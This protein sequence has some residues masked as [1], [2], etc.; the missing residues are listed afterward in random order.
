MLSAM[1]DWVKRSRRK[2]G[3]QPMT[4]FL[5]DKSNSGFPTQ[6]PHYTDEESIGHAASCVVQVEVGNSGGNCTAIA[7]GGGGELYVW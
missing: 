5:F 6:G 2:L 4:Q 7:L 3:R 1:K